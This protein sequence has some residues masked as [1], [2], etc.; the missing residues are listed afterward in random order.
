MGWLD[1]AHQEKRERERRER[2]RRSQETKGF[3]DRRQRIRAYVR[4][5]DGMVR[6]NLGEIARRTWHHP[7]AFWEGSGVE[8][9]ADPLSDDLHYSWRAFRKRR[10]RPPCNVFEVYVLFDDKGTPLRFGVGHQLWGREVS[11]YFAGWKPWRQETESLTE[12]ALRELLKIYYTRGPCLM[13][14]SPP[15]ELATWPT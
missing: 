5:I 4:G 3:S 12:D 1:E 7:I 6:T 14:P 8:I 2:E 15:P 10:T 9:R 13:P 11:V